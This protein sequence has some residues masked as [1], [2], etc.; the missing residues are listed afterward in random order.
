MLQIG[1]YSEDE[2]LHLSTIVESAEI[3]TLTEPVSSPLVNEN[4]RS[5]Y[6]RSFEEQRPPKTKLVINADLG[7]K[8]E[9]DTAGDVLPVFSYE[10]FI[11]RTWTLVVLAVA[12]CGTCVALWMFIYVLLKMCDG[13]L[14][15]NQTMGLILLMGVTALF[16]SV[17]PWLLP[18]NEMI[19]ATRHFLHP[20]VMVLCFAIL[21]V[22]A[23]QLRSLVSIGLGGT[24]PQIN[25][26]V[27]LLFMLLVQ[28]VIVGEWY[29]ASRPLGVRHTN[30]YPECG[31]SK[32]R[33]L[34]LH[35]YPA[36]LLFL[37]FF[38]GISVLKIKRNFN[39][40]RWITTATIF[41]I[42]IFAAWSFVYYFAPVQFHDP[43]VAV[44]IVAVAGILLATIFLPK[45]H[46]IVHQSKVKSIG[47][48]GSTDSTV[49]TGFSDF[50]SPFPPS[51]SHQ[52]YYP[53]YPGPYAPAA[54]R[55]IGGP[56]GGPYV[57]QFR[58]PPPPQQRL[59]HD[60]NGLNFVSGQQRRGA[61]VTSY[62]DW[63]RELQQHHQ[64][65]RPSRRHS[66]SP[67]REAAGLQRP[68]KTSSSRGGQVNHHRRSR[69]KSSSRE[70]RGRP[71]H[72]SNN[73]NNMKIMQ[74]KQTNPKH[75]LR[76]NTTQ[77]MNNTS[78]IGVMRLPSHSP[79]DGMILTASGLSDTISSEA[80]TK[81]TSTSTDHETSNVII[82]DGGSHID[83]GGND[84][85]YLN[86]S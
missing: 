74:Q 42:P 3:A 53:V 55:P 12:M 64:Q 18:P 49:F 86:T 30:G 20:L 8:I 67:E 17:I 51:K 11:S 61:R 63:T 58:P 1:W 72:K 4:D 62:A 13:T 81:M 44:S 2:G 60:F 33:F 56:L 26:I 10:S 39:E 32:N 34:L 79:S 73:N 14:T 36:T 65:Q 22:K 27:S 9:D 47:R 71:R 5:L 40:G 48:T 50:I 43:S 57:P 38:Y 75:F 76:I 25:Q 69:S 54:R 16:A 83:V 19:C 82:L 29:V 7:A 35:L 80:T 45:M 59:Q 6:G 70:S 24:I 85:V 37:A 78:S 52:K 31:V 41:I 21:L 23:I 46:T 15:G 84:S 77:Y 68:L 66:V 28:V